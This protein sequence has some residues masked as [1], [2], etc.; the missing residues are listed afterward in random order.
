MALFDDLATDVTAIMLS[1]APDT[2]DVLRVTTSSDGAGGQAQGTPATVSP[3]GI[4]CF[5]E[6]KRSN[7]RV[8]G[9]KAEAV[10]DYI[11]YLPVT[12][13][14]TAVDVTGRDQVRVAARGNQPARTFQ[15]TGV[16]QIQGIII[17][18]RALLLNQ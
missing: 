1:V 11:I 18:V 2:C 12:H 6:A 8:A 9:D 13:S 7:E 5:Y 17:Q 4:P 16:E 10:G 3:T 15:V 14:G